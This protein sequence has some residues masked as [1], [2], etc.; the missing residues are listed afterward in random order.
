M[1]HRL[2]L[3]HPIP[4]QGASAVLP[5]GEYLRPERSRA[6]VSAAFD[7]HP[8]PST[9]AGR[10]GERTMTDGGTAR[11]ESATGTLAFGTRMDRQM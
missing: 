1:P 7:S 11:L 9:M 2:P 3:H 5:G 6:D 10:M 4:I 8:G